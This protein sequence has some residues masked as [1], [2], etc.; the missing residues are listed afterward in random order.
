MGGFLST[1]RKTRVSRLRSDELAETFLKMS[2]CLGAMR[3]VVERA[4]SIL[5]E[6]TAQSINTMI[7]DTMIGQRLLRRMERVRWQCTIPQR[8][9]C[10]KPSLKLLTAILGMHAWS[11]YCYHATRSAWTE[12]DTLS[13]DKHDQGL[14]M[15]NPAN[16]LGPQSATTVRYTPPADHPPTSSISDPATAGITPPTINPSP[17]RVHDH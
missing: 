14:N 1:V 8:H 6:S 15:T 13:I 2:A 12:C 11:C 7:I 17:H 16:L 4:A 10:S 9:F 3:V 5:S